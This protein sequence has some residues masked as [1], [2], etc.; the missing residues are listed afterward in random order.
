MGRVSV[1]YTFYKGQ[2]FGRFL[3]G[4]DSLYEIETQ[5][6]SPESENT[7]AKYQNTVASE[8]T[9]TIFGVGYRRNNHDKTAHKVR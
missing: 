9:I 5:N 8:H 7:I 4:W 3:V 1:A 6:F 2:F